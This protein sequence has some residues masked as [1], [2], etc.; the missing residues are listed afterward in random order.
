MAA[1]SGPELSSKETG[2]AKNVP[3]YS[4]VIPTIGRPEMLTRTLASLAAQTSKPREVIVIDAS[5]N[6]EIGEVCKG[7]APSLPVRCYL[8]T[9]RSAARQRNEGAALAT[10]EL[11][12]FSDD[13]M[14]YRSDAMERLCSVWLRDDGGDIGGVAA[15]IEGF[16]HRKPKGLLWLYYRLQAGYYHE[17]Y[18]GHLFGPAINCIPTYGAGSE[19]L[20]PAMWL[21]SGCVMYSRRDFSKEKFPEFEG[22]S[23]MEDVHL[24]AR[25]AKTSKLFF[26]RSA[27]VTH[28][29]GRGGAE[30]ISLARMQMRARNQKL[31]ALEVMNLHPMVFFFKYLLHKLFL[32]VA[33]MRRPN[34]RCMQCILGL[35]MS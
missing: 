8:S 28:L 7:W 33:L 35:W 22:Y 15:K 19:D 32:T 10:S 34:R 26:H 12:L 23:F 27:V 17:D 30:D 11:I 20:I 5:G 1:D 13:D 3:S 4:V 6:S 24:S 25:I 16:E 9:A 2:E 18:G 14:E 21:N 29:E 31:V